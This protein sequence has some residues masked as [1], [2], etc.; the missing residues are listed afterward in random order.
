[1]CALQ[2]SVGLIPAASD[3]LFAFEV[4]FPRGCSPLIFVDG[5]GLGRG[6]DLDALMTPDQ[7]EGMEV[8]TGGVQIPR[9]Y[10]QT[11]AACGAIVIWATL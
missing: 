3:P 2:T 1:M 4:T 10:S 9:Q 5:V 8:Y 11:G 6:I 7:V